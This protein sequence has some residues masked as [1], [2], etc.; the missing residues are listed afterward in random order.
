MLNDYF[1]GDHAQQMLKIVL[2]SVKKESWLA[3]VIHC[4]ILSVMLSDRL[5]GVDGNST[6]K[7]DTTFCLPLRHLQ[8]NI[9]ITN[10]EEKY[11]PIVPF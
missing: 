10:I 11:S 5:L 9:K 6:H 7:D 1:I 4:N 2:P 8:N 3:T